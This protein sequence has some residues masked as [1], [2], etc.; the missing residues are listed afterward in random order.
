MLPSESDTKERR[1]YVVLPDTASRSVGFILSCNGGHKLSKDKQIQFCAN[2]V[3][4][5]REPAERA[6]HWRTEATILVQNMI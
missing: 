4:S 2:E 3:K 6:G 1:R 5:C